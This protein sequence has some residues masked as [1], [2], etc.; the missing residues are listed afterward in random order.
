MAYKVI[1]IVNES[2]IRIVI[3]FTDLLHFYDYSFTFETTLI[4]NE[5]NSRCFNCY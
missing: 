4:Y 2:K 1:E 3:D 5:K